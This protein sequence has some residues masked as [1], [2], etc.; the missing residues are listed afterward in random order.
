MRGTEFAEMAAF[1][2]IAEGRSFAKAAARL[3]LARSTVSQNLRALEERL[4][5]RLLNRTTRSVSL[6][7]AGERLLAR[8]RPALGELRMAGEEIKDSRR[9]PAG[10][11]RL[12]VQPPVAS[13][14]IG[15]IL[16][17]FLAEYPSI[18]LDVAVVKM[19]ADIVRDGF[20]AGIRLG[21][22]VERDMIAMRVMGEARFLVVASP[23]YLTLH[24]APKSPRD[25]QQHNCIRNRLPNGAIFGWEFHKGSRSIQAIVDGSLIVDD[26]DLS[27]RAVLDG[28]GLAYLLHDYVASHLASGRLVPLLESW[29]PRLSGFF[30]YHPSR[31]QVTAQLRALID[32]LKV[33][34]RR[35]GIEPSASPRGSVHPN[36]RLAGK[37]RK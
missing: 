31:R 11:L 22:Q 30:L 25:L 37:G 35:R 29:S 1:V 32:F 7:E 16:A 28:I 20:D 17:R 26:I 15:P 23:E 21:E 24:P 9:G 2:A 19:P 6:T 4:G 27:I 13:L 36:Y 33:E 12:V 8:V 34:T 18:R 14:L 10:V 5:V 3:R